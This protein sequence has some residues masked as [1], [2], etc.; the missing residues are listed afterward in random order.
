M[1]V[2][3]TVQGFAGDG[4]AAELGSAWRWSS[5]S[6]EGSGQA[7]VREKGRDGRE[8]VWEGL[9]VSDLEDRE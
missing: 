4:A 5:R 2:G 6:G 1:K 8:A 7:V 3:S 9:D